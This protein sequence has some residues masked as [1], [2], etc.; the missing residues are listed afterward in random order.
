L[1]YGSNEA[2]FGSSRD[3]RLALWIPIAYP[4]A[5]I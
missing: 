5:C 3:V 1:N 2:F 4:P